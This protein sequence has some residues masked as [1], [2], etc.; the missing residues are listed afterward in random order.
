VKGLDFD[1]N[2]QL[3]LGFRASA[4]G[5]YTIALSGKDGF[6]TSQEVYLEDKLLNVI[7][8]FS[9]GGAYT[10][11]TDAGTF[12]ERFV[13]RYTEA[14]VLGVQKPVFNDNSVIVYKDRN[15]INFKTAGFTMQKIK[16][17]DVNGRE[18]LVRN[19]VDSETAV[20]SNLSA[21]QQM[22]LIR[23]TSID[24]I[25]VTKKIVF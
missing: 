17:F 9:T 23:I 8:S 20:V 18:L 1:V 2:E 13:I 21:A 3:P 10:F 19:N 12:N 16:I 6:F 25:T 5:T 7:H 11:V 15:G 4:A 14:N 22:L 24:G